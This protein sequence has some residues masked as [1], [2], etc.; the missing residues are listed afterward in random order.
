MRDEGTV[1]T[2]TKKWNTEG[3]KGF[4]PP[5]GGSPS[6]SESGIAW[7]LHLPRR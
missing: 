4:E 2:L 5:E 6:A 3:P 1:M 7:E